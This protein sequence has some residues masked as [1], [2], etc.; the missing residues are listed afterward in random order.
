MERLALAL[1]S[2]SRRNVVFHL[3]VHEAQRTAKKELPSALNYERHS[4][5][6]WSSWFNSIDEQSSNMDEW[7]AVNAPLRM[8]TFNAPLEQA[9]LVLYDAFPRLVE[10][11]KLH[12]NVQ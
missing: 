10:A 3:G 6:E 9:R 2:K 4:R 12:V 8:L 11:A 1:P 7:A 5:A